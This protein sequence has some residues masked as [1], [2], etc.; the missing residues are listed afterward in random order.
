MTLSCFEK[1]LALATDD[2]MSD[3]WY[4]VGQIAIGIG[5]LNLAYQAFKI[6]ISVDANHAESFNNLGVKHEHASGDILGLHA[7]KASCSL[8]DLTAFLS[9]RSLAAASTLTTALF[10][11]VQILELRKGNIEQ[12]RS[13]F[14]SSLRLSPHL[15]EPFFN[16]ALVAFKLGDCQESFDMAQKALEAFPGQNR[17]KGHATTTTRQ[18]QLQRV[19]CRRWTPGSPFPVLA[20]LLLSRHVTLSLCC[21]CVTHRSH[22]L[23]G[24]AEATEEALHHAVRVRTGGGVEWQRGRNL[25]IQTG[26]P[27]EAPPQLDRMHTKL[28]PHCR[29]LHC[30]L[31]PP[32]MCKAA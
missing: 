8:A 13:N 1:A 7:C 31:S 12:A 9:A 6:A 22:R 30:S 10:L 2:N 16:G 24:A 25:T 23:Q 26:P 32:R 4:N 14:Q 27:P 19:L 3:V 15:F 11:F 17:R 20:A 5:D 18:D 21:P 29:P 28:Q